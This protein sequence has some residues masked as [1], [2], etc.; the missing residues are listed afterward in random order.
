[1][2]EC[3]RTSGGWALQDASKR[4]AS[5]SVLGECGWG[6]GVRGRCVGGTPCVLNLI[7]FIPRPDLRGGRIADNP[8][9]QGDCR[10]H[11]AE[12]NAALPPERA[13][14]LSRAVSKERRAPW[15]MAS[16]DGRGRR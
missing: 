9:G 15:P 5:G 13:A 7:R 10:G 8:Y 6:A 1:M 3:I 2:T 11:E 12:K 16:A 14:T 4:R